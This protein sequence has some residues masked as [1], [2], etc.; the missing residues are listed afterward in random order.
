MNVMFKS[1]LVPIFSKSLDFCHSHN[2]LTC[3]KSDACATI[4]DSTF[5]ESAIYDLA[6]RCSKFND[7]PDDEEDYKMKLPLPT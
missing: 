4:F 1:D 6:V 7:A 5:I 2:C 3:P